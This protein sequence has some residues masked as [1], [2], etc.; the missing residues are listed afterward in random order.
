MVSTSDE[1]KERDILKL[2]LI[3]R[4]ACTTLDVG[5]PIYS[6]Y[7]I[8][9]LFHYFIIPSQC[10]STH[11]ITSR[12]NTAQHD[13]WQSLI[14]LNHSQVSLIPS[15]WF[16][17]WICNWFQRFEI[18]WWWYVEMSNGRYCQSQVSI[19]QS[20]PDI[21]SYI[22]VRL[23]HQYSIQEIRSG[24]RKRETGKSLHIN[25]PI[26]GSCELRT[27]MDSLTHIWFIAS[28]Q[29]GTHRTGWSGGRNKTT[30]NNLMT[31]QSLITYSCS[32]SFS[33]PFSQSEPEPSPPPEP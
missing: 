7:L 15:N 6:R 23:I 1:L 14:S 5:H 9:S 28:D 18:S 24:D 31:S 33:F 20:I 8:I 11:R 26:L 13:W 22:T 12:D 4:F 3:V 30:S 19:C 27:L 25:W 16:Q 21:I 2:I 32:G 17:A 10:W 29:G